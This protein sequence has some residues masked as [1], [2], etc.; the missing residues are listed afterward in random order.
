MKNA[1]VK[2]AVLTREVQVKHSTNGQLCFNINSL[3]TRTRSRD[4]GYKADAVNPSSTITLLCVVMDE[5]HANSR[6]NDFFLHQ[7]EMETLSN[8]GVC[9]LTHCHHF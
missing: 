8:V 6:V 9:S 7:L 2:R 4:H 1:C 3:G 5:L